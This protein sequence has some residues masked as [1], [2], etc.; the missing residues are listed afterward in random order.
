M[1]ARPNPLWRNRLRLARRSRAISQKELAALFGV[2]PSVLSRAEYQRQLP[3]LDLVF[4]YEAL[5]GQPVN[6]LFPDLYCDVAERV[7]A[8]TKLL[9]EALEGKSG[10]A[11]EVKRAFLDQAIQDYEEWS[12]KGLDP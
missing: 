3:A 9:R 10:P 2:A 7:H 11:V 1:V 6:N 12:L 4:A 5:F 8:N